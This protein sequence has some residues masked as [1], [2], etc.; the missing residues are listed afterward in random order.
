MELAGAIV[1]L[2]PRVARALDKL[3]LPGEKRE[4]TIARIVWAVST[5]ETRDET[6]ARR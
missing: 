2:D 4:D 6:R 5:S 1:R 3:A